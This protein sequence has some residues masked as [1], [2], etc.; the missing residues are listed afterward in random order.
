M[1]RGRP[2]FQGDSEI[3]QLFQIFRILKTPTD[4]DWPG[5]TQ[6]PDYKP[7]FPKWAENKLSKKMAVFLDENGMDLLTVSII[8]FWFL[9]IPKAF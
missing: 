9:C 6:F 1:A 4:Q 7:S 3:D 8:R 2:L 5:V